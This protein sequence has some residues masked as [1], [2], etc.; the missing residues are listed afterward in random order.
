M[1][2][3]Q[4]MQAEHSSGMLGM[5]SQARGLSG[6][7]MVIHCSKESKYTSYAHVDIN[8]MYRR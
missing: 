2:A 6:V 8:Q 7:L 1:L 4:S 3:K 5:V